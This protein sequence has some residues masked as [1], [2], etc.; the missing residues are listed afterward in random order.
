MLQEDIFYISRN[1]DSANWW[2]IIIPLK[3]ILNQIKQL[4]NKQIHL[5]KSFYF[6]THFE[7]QITKDEYVRIMNKSFSL[8]K[9]AK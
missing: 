3:K 8:F 9:A 1:S 7:N 5:K 6:K 2:L 4:I